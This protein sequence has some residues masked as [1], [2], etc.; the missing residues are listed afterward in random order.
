MAQP[1]FRQRVTA[2]MQQRPAPI[3]RLWQLV[4]GLHYTADAVIGV[5]EKTHMGIRDHVVLNVAA[6]AGVPESS[7]KTFRSRHDRVFGGLYRGLRTV[8]WF[9]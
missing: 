9:V 6:R 1:V 7:I 5:I 2:W 8:H 4:D 3:P